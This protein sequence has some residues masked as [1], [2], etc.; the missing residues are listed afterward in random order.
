MIP[1]FLRCWQSFSGLTLTW[2][3]WIIKGAL[4]LLIGGI[5]GS[6]PVAALVKE[7]RIDCTL[8]DQH[9]NKGPIEYPERFLLIWS[10]SRRYGGIISWSWGTTVLTE[11][12]LG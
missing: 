11:H 6:P 5:H 7:P 1:Y 2:Y 3:E 4:I 9:Y 12:L 10:T 8:N